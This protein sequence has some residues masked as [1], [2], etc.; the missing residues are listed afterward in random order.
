MLGNKQQGSRIWKEWVIPSIKV[1]QG[2]TGQLCEIISFIKM[3]R[4]RRSFVEMKNKSETHCVF[5]GKLCVCVC[6]C[7]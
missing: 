3:E 6:V 7:V 1:R 2:L 4:G 5:V